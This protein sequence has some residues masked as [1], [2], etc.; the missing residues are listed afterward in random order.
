M[1]TVLLPQGVNQISVKPLETHKCNMW[2]NIGLLS[3]TA[4][5]AR[6]YLS[7]LNG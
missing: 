7:A 2:A 4:D 1:C 5:V 3:V 6:N